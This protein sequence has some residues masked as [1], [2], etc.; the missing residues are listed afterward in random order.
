MTLITRLLRETELLRCG[1]P[2]LGEVVNLP[3]SPS[4]IARP[5]DLTARRVEKVFNLSGP[6]RTRIIEV[7]PSSE[8]GS[9]SP[10]HGR[11]SEHTSYLLDAALNHPGGRTGELYAAGRPPRGYLNRR[12]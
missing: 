5:K 3:A 8:R 2:G 9:E 10:S 7:R 11:R 6:P 4:D 12:R 1:N